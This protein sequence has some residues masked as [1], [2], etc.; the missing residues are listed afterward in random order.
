MDAD[1]SPPPM[2]RG[3][4]LL[5]VRVNVL[6]GTVVQSLGL[7]LFTEMSARIHVHCA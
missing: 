2:A 5:A 4:L 1:S 7:W 6:L 3:T